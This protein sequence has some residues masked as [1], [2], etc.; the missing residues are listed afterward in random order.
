[1]SFIDDLRTKVEQSAVGSAV[2]SIEGYFGVTAAAADP[3]VIVNPNA[4]NANRTALDLALGLFNLPP[5]TAGPIAPASATQNASPRPP[6]QASMPMWILP[7]VAVAGVYLLT[8]R[9]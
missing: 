2:T 1:M 7:L 5:M 6:P 9:S 8:R 4:P 3:Q